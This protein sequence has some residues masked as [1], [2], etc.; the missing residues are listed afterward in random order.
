MARLSGNGGGGIVDDA[1]RSCQVRDRDCAFT[2]GQVEPGAFREGRRRD[3]DGSADHGRH[4]HRFRGARW[5]PGEF[6][7]NGADE[8]FQALLV[9][10]WQTGQGVAL[11]ANSDNGIAVAGELLR[12]VAREYEWKYSPGPRSA[13]EQMVLLAE[14]EGPAAVLQEFDQLKAAPAGKRPE[15]H[16]LNMIGYRVFMQA[17]KTDDAIR[18]FAKNAQEYPESSNVYDSLGEAYAAAGKKDLAIENYE[19]SLR[20]DPKNE[21]AKDWLAKLK[22]EK[23]GQR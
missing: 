11:M 4:W 21:N 8:G 14:L 23:T 18:V 9:M 12:S 16:V 15:E 2:A 20:L 22:G 6:G 19:K 5:R 3:A 1:D 17:G 13:G 10:N 7:H